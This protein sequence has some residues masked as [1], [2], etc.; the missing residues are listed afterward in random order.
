MLTNAQCVEAVAYNERRN[1][2][3]DV[4]ENIQRLV[5]TGVDGTWGTKSVQAVAEWQ[6]KHRLEVDGKVGPI[7]L[8][9]MKD[10]ITVGTYPVMHPLPKITSMWGYDHCPNTYKKSC[11]AWHDATKEPTFVN[12]LL[13]LVSGGHDERDRFSRSPDSWISLD[14]LSIGI[15]HWWAETAPKI[16]SAIAQKLPGVAAHAWGTTAISMRGIDWLRAQ[17]RAKRG[18]RPHQAKY[19]WLLSGWWEVGQHPEVVE[20]CARQW[21]SDYTPAGLALMRKYDWRE[22]T[23]LA[24][25]VRVTNSRGAGG[26]KSLVKRAI[27]KAGTHCEGEILPIVFNDEDLYDHPE[28]WEVITSL[29]HFEGRAPRSVTLDEFHYDRDLV[30]RV[31]GSVPAWVA[32]GL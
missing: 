29:P 2:S 6:D 9:I 5:G 16:L 8:R 18:K 11:P 4:V 32:A 3:Q 1:Y 17:I 13:R 14:E 21:L 22:G 26:M 12:G 15:A 27:T 28:R 31:D 24:G 23:T 30:V 10:E 20:L 7:T 19:D 25:L